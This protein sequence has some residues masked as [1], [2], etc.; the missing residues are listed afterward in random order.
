M[1]VPVSLTTNADNCV[2]FKILP[3]YVC[4]NTLR[5]QNFSFP[6]SRRFSTSSQTVDFVYS[7]TAPRKGLF[8][9]NKKISEVYWPL[10]FYQLNA[11][12]QT[13]HT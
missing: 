2:N 3:S 5:M 13:C 11:F 1:D 9:C 6:C 4:L 7:L 12:I 8:L 10:R